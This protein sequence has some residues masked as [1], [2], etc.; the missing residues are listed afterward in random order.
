MSAL[1]HQ[2]TDWYLSA[3]D[4]G[5]YAL[6]AGLMALESTLVPLPSE[7]IIPPAAYV[8][9]TQGH[10]SFLGIVIAGTLG[11]WV[12]ASIMFF[13]SFILKKNDPSGAHKVTAE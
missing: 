5:G 6:I 8:A 4:S 3:L 12:G 9:H 7:L 13:L 11:S 1:L 10:L 2:F